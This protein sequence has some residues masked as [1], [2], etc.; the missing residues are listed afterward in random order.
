MNRHE[1]DLR[2]I[3]T[4]RDLLRRMGAGIGS[5][6]LAATLAEGGLL[7]ADSPQSARYA[8]SRVIVGAQSR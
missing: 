4:R 5:I 7:A 1:T 6:G 2:P 3:L 8:V